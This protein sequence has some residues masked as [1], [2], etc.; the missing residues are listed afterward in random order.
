MEARKIALNLGCGLDYKESTDEIRWINTDVDP[1][2]KTDWCGDAKNMP[3]GWLMYSG[4]ERAEEDWTNKF[5]HIYSHHSLEH[6]P[7]L[8]EI[9][10]EMV[11]VSKNGATWEITVPYWS[12]SQNQ[13]NPHHHIYFSE[14]TFDFFGEKYKRGHKESWTLEVVDIKYGW[15]DGYDDEFHMYRHQWLNVVKDL[16]FKIIVRK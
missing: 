13:G 7:D 4:M 11:R 12:W 5:D 8:I 6:F 1:D 9:V 3:Y 16:T 2:V 14:H 10:H 15:A